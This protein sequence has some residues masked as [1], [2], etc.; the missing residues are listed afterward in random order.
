MVSR[1]LFSDPVKAKKARRP[2]FAALNPGY[3]S[4]AEPIV[5]DVPNGVLGQ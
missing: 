1:I 3:Y 4:L 2:D 5:A